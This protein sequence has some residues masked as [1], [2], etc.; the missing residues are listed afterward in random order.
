M[1]SRISIIKGIHPGIIL[2]RELRKRKLAKKE[3]AISINEHPQTITSITKSK[4][5]MN[6]ALSLKIESA[7][8]LEEGFLMVLQAYYD[9]EQ[10]K[11]KRIKSFHPDLSKIR[12]VVF[13]DTDIYKIDWNKNKYAVIT[14]IAERGNEAEMAEIIRFYGQADVDSVLNNKKNALLNKQ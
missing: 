2:E 14:R 3:F 13:W 5:R 9:I 10:E 4:R 8:N 1:D 7:L 12:S 11:K 6:P